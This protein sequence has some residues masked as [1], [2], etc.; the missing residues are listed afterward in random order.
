M[1]TMMF[2]FVESEE[3]LYH[4]FMAW[5]YF[6]VIK[7]D[8]YFQK[9]PT[10]RVHIP[11]VTN[12]LIF[13]KWH[14]DSFLG[15]S[16]RDINVWFGLTDNIKSDFHIKNLKGSSEWFGDYEYDKQRF[17]QSAEKNSKD[18]NDHGF[19]NSHE[20]QDIFNSIFLFDSRCIHTAVHRSELDWTT[21][22]SIDV[23]LILTDDFEWVKI[24][25]KPVFIGDGL[26][27]AEFRPGSEYG[28]HKNSIKEIIDESGRKV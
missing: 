7:K 28:Y 20:V 23:R 24:D 22:F 11:G 6:N 27:K 18:F 4:D 3:R 19:L 13:P 16:P 15:H 25:G 2:D 12:N 14:S 17:I 10:T 5:L 8:F 1:Q 26:R 9:V 21:K